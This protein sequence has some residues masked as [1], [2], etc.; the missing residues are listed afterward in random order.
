MRTN[1]PS[2]ENDE[3]LAQAKE[4]VRDYRQRRYA[5]LGESRYP[6]YPLNARNPMFRISKFDNAKQFRVTI[7]K[8]SIVEQGNI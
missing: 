8:H 3:E 7:V 2:D 4:Q 5:P 1:C 6:S